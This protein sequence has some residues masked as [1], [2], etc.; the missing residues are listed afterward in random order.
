MHGVPLAM[1]PREQRE[2]PMLVWSSDKSLQYK[3]LPEVGQHH[4]F[5][6]VLRFFGIESPAFNEELCIFAP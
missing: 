2:I 6:S 5:H 4:V 3:D 1:A